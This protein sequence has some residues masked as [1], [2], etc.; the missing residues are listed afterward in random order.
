VVLTGDV[1]PDAARTIGNVA[2]FHRAM[3][4]TLGPSAAGLPGVE[5]VP[6]DAP[7]TKPGLVLTDGEVPADTPIPVLQDW[8]SAVSA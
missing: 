5:S 7:A 2:R 3:A 6:L 8:I 4:H 1:D